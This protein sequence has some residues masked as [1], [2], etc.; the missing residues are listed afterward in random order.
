MSIYKYKSSWKAEVWVDQKRIASRSGFQTKDDAKKWHAQEVV[1]FEQ[2]PVTAKRQTCTFDD[3]LEKFASLHLPT[4]SEGTRLRYLLDIELRIRPYFQF[5]PID[6][7][8]RMAIESF[9]AGIMGGLSPKS[10]N[11]CTD[12]LGIIFR[13]GVGWGMLE[14]NPMDLKALKLPEVKYQWW[15]K[16]EHIA[17]FLAEAKKTRHYAAYKLALECGLRLGEIVGLSKQDVDLKRCQLHIHRQWLDPGMCYGPT[18]GRRERF[19]NFDPHSGLKEALAEAM[20]KSPYPD[21]IFV[22][23]EARRVRSRKLVGRH[24]P[25]LIRRAKCLRFVSTICVTLSLPGL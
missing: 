4:I 25:M 21:V 1:R 3:L 16:K 9:R 8:D 5:R 2:T 6:K 12:L 14:K 11:N 7:I 24:F 23:Q 10:V 19:I 13:K 22:N 17:R 15:D 20:L 18:K